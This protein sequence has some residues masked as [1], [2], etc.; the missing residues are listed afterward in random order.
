[1]D[2][3]LSGIEKRMASDLFFSEKGLASEQH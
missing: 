1:V 2:E 3:S